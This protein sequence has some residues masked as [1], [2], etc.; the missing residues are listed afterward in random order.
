[1][2]DEAEFLRVKGL[3]TDEVFG[4]VEPVT[5]E[6]EDMIDFSLVDDEKAVQHIDHTLE[7]C[8]EEAA[9]LESYSTLLRKAGWDGISKQTAKAMLIGLRR[10]ERLSGASSGLVAALEDETGGELARTQNEQ[11]KTDQKGIM[12]KAVDVWKRFVEFIKKHLA[13]LVEKARKMGDYLQTGI[14]RKIDKLKAAYENFNPNDANGGRKVTI[15]G[16]VAQW[17]YPNG[18]PVDIAAIIRIRKWAAQT[19]LPTVRGLAD[20]VRK[21]TGDETAEQIRE[22]SPGEIP[23][24]GFSIDGFDLNHDDGFV[25]NTEANDIEVTVRDRKTAM[26]YLSEISSVSNAE[27]VP[28]AASQASEIVIDMMNVASKVTFAKGTDVYLAMQEVIRRIVE[29]ADFVFAISK[30]TLN[31]T[32]NALTILSIESG[33]GEKA[34]NEEFDY[35]LEADEQPG[36]LKR[37]A[38]FLKGLW[39]KLIAKW[40]QLRNSEAVL[41]AKADSIKAGFKATE[42]EVDDGPRKVTVSASVATWVVTDGKIIPVGDW[43][44]SFKYVFEDL[45][46]AFD[47]FVAKLEE[48]YKAGD[49]E[50]LQGLADGTIEIPSYTDTLP[51]GAKFSVEA[52]QL[53][54]VDMPETGAE[55]LELPSVQE[56][57]KMIDAVPQLSKYVRGEGGVT[58]NS[59]ATRLSKFNGLV[60]NDMTKADKAALVK[61]GLSAQ[62]RLAGVIRP[63]HTIGSEFGTIGR[64][65]FELAAL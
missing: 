54:L 21:L 27:G 39:D 63:A 56:L 49:V 4:T 36:V 34:S 10:R 42:A 52:G 65:Y 59:V 46:K 38:E 3:D 29:T 62:K 51:N 14:H 16:N 11:S 45:P 43:L 2:R 47:P 35:G 57:T 26:A 24:P 48:A 5:E 17:G 64:R 1:M 22:L 12:G 28:S 25:P 23:D 32:G 40:D 13:K 15:P 31:M 19:V 41:D 33:D 18:K 9:A 30:A 61:V 8:V 53:T 6:K 44:P 55:E 60:I 50:T 20:R 37:I 58:Y 7:E